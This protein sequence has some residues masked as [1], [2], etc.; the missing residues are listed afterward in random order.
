MK[1]DT[2]VNRLYEGDRD[3]E[4][5]TDIQTHQTWKGNPGDVKI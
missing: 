3:K 1:N 4:R 2:D 5:N